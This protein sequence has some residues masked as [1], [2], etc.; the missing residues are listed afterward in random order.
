VRR[1]F[2]SGTNGVPEANAIVFDARSS[3]LDVTDLV[4]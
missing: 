4:P 2:E 1:A 3:R